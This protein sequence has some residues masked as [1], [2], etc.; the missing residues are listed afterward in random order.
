MG[1]S[2]FSGVLSAFKDALVTYRDRLQSMAP[3]L[4]FLAVILAILNMQGISLDG[5]PSTMIVVYSITML[6]LQSMAIIYFTH[7]MNGGDGPSFPDLFAHRGAL[8][9]VA[10][11]L[12]VVFVAFVLIMSLGVLACF[13]IALVLGMLLPA[14]AVGLTYG[15]FILMIIPVAITARLVFAPFVIARGDHTES[16]GLKEAWCTTRCHGL[17]I[18]IV[19]AI[20]SAV[21][22]LTVE[23]LQLSPGMPMRML[24]GFLNG[25][26]IT[27]LSVLS[28]AAF[29]KNLTCDP[30]K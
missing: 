24:G 15:A 5:M 13:L 4:A 21:S 27:P 3:F 6:M 28:L 10:I 22:I 16:F 17:S 29:Q 12:V 7:V 11:S 1:C 2:C 19:M 25:A 14:A 18:L 26:L 23:M 9:R 20:I 30:K 8:L